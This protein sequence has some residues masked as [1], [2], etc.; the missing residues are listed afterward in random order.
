MKSPQRIELESTFSE[1]ILDIISHRYEFAQSE[2][3]AM[4]ATL[5]SE[6]LDAGEAQKL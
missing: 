6:M 3:R 5:V 1:K 2:V 4:V